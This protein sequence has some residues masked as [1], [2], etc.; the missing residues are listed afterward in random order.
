MVLIIQI[1]QT[2]LKK[3]CVQRSDMSGKQNESGMVFLLTPKG[4]PIYEENQ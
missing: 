1:S 3:N 2:W 4:S